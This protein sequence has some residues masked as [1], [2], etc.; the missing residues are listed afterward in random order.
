MRIFV[1]GMS[2]ENMLSKAIYR[3]RDCV[4]FWQR[5][6][7]RKPQREGDFRRRAKFSA[8]KGSPKLGV[9]ALGRS[10]GRGGI[11]R[12]PALEGTPPLSFTKPVSKGLSL[13]GSL[14]GGSLTGL[15]AGIRSE[16]ACREST[17]SLGTG[18]ILPHFQSWAA[19]VIGVALL[20]FDARF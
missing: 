20:L 4:D 15:D 16:V 19:P 9:G 14:L 13:G 10:R 7:V 18:T 12:L 2:F 5:L 6:T 3:T 8:D 17:R 1:C 11:V